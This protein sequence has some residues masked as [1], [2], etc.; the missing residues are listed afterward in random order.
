MNIKSKTKKIKF[1][2]TEKGT[3][4]VKKLLKPLAKTDQIILQK[5]ISQVEDLNLNN[6][7]IT[8]SKKINKKWEVKVTGN[9]SECN[10]LFKYT[11]N[12]HNNLTI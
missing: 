6:I 1:I 4:S 9:N 2:E 8:F 5:S 11:I 7:K 3:I 10:F 12:K